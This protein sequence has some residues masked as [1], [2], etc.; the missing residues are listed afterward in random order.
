MCLASF[1]FK[2]NPEVTINFLYSV[3]LSK[4]R[5]LIFFITV[6]FMLDA[7]HVSRKSSPLMTE[8]AR[9]PVVAH[10]GAWKKNNLPENSIASLKHAIAL[11]CTGSEFDVRMSMDDSLVINH[12]PDYNRLVIEKSSYSRLA[13]YK[14]SNGE[15][16]PTLREYLRAGLENN[17]QTMLVLE[18]KPS[19][20][21]KERA[22]F[23]AEKIVQLVHEMNAQ[24]MICY[25]SFDYAILKKIRE[26]DPG[27]SLQY[28][29]G[30]K[31]PDELKAGGLNGADYHYSVFR[32]HPEWIESAKKNKIVLNAW[33]VND[34]GDMDWLLAK[35]FDFITTNEPELLFERI[36]SVQ[37]NENAEDSQSRY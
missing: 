31:S 4:N 5:R 19:G 36:R 7:C 24:P 12:D 23:I 26:I 6:I 1:I 29:N 14:L 35:D 34:A 28:L 30:D 27:A 25:I 33:T 3:I 17:R 32:T 37:K 8:F 10:R 20:T 15:K 16:I 22:E 13:E 21:G 2:D 18:I 11:G 9:N